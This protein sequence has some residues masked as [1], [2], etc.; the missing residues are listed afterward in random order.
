MISAWLLKFNINNNLI[1][2]YPHF[3]PGCFYTCQG[4]SHTRVLRMREGGGETHLV[5]AHLLCM[6]ANFALSSLPHLQGMEKKTCNVLAVGVLFHF[7]VEMTLCLVIS[8][9]MVHRLKPLV[10]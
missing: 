5:F 6:S 1:I 2:G 9:H 3:I 10:K 4:I 7:L 8:C